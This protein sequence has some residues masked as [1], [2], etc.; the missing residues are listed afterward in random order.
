MKDFMKK[1]AVSLVDVVIL[2]FGYLVGRCSVHDNF[3]G[4]EGF[5]T[6][7]TLTLRDTIREVF[8]MIVDVTISED[9]IEVPVTDIVIRN[10]SLVV[11]PIEVKTYEGQDY[12]AQVSGYRPQLDWIEVFPETKYIT[13]TISD[14]RDNML[15]FSGE[16]VYS[17]RFTT[18]A[19]FMYQRKWRYVSIE[20]GAGYDIVNNN[21][22]I[23]ARVKF[24]IF[25]W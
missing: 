16:V 15:Y 24:P 2:L 9:D 21:A 14:I 17:D 13:N 4:K 1:I 5:A 12:R 11:L 25:R 19:L 10:D 18:A 23:L 8:P 6:T 20:A 3:P 7:D 22:V